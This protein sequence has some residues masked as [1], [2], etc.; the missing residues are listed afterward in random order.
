MVALSFA[1]P[2]IAGLTLERQIESRLGTPAATAAG[3]VL[4]A[5]AMALADRAPQE[6]GRGD[7]TRGGRARAGARRRRRR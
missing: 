1:P 5:L 7:A 3:L 4:G 6:R 2:A